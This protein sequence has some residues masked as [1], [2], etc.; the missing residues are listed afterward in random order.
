MIALPEP[1]AAYFGGQ[2]AADAA[3][4]LACFADDAVVV[5]E[6]R[7]IRGL[8]AIR[9]WRQE[10]TDRYRPTVEPIAAS[11]SGGTTIV[12]ARVSGPFPG[13]PVTLEFRF[14]VRGDKIAT[15]EIA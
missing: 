1:I 15:L 3:A 9:T 13:S 6:Q 7:E 10:T 2:N 5:D 8:A 11:Q 4:A 12:S 14:G